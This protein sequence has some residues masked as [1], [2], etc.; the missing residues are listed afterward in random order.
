MS[1]AVYFSSSPESGNTAR[2]LTSFMKGLERG[3][4][5]TRTFDVKEIRPSPCTGEMHCWFKDPGSCYI[6]DGMQDFYPVLREADTLVLG[7]PVYIPLPGEMQNLL[8]RLCPIVEPDLETREGR[9]RA[10]VRDGYRL[11]R[12]ALVATGGW[13][14]IENLDTVVRIA[15][16]FAE[17]ASVPFV[18]AV[19]R[20]HAAMAL[21]PQGKPAE[22]LEAAEQAGFEL[23]SAGEIRPET[24]ATVSQPLIG[25]EDYRQ[26]MNQMRAGG[27]G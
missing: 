27:G 18:G 7:T 12:V 17:D 11:S 15:R 26:Y 1:V 5:E 4:D 14:E 13:W 2:L 23:V 3:G 19:L 25:Q 6:Q 22:I 9:T 16:E 8:N 21:S 24:L 20:P 10:R